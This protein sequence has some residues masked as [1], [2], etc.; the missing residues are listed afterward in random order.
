MPLT[1]HRIAALS[2]G[3][4]VK[5]ARAEMK[6]RI[7]AGEVKISVILHAPTLLD[8]L[9]G[10]ELA[11]L[12]AAIHGVSYAMARELC[13]EL[14]IP[15]TKPLGKTTYRQR[16]IIASHV[17]ARW[18]AVPAEPQEK[19]RALIHHADHKPHAATRCA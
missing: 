7:K 17:G 11:K 3:V 19:G 9:V 13:E 5:Q 4:R 16:R 8:H 1:D 18:E 2:K 10:M 6:H 15:A 12:L 14:R